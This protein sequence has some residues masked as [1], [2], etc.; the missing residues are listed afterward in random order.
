MKI[1]KNLQTI[2]IIVIVAA[3]L[4]APLYS[5]E[6]VTGLDF[7]DRVAENY[8]TIQDYIADFD[9]T[10]EENS[11]SGLIYYKN[12]NLIRIDFVDPEEQVLVTDGSVM[13]VYV[14]RYNVTLTQRLKAQ[15]NPGGFATGEGLSMLRRNYQIA[16]LDSP[17]PQPLDGP[18]G[19]STEPVYKL[20][21]TWRNTAQGFREITIS[22]TPD[23]FIRRMTAVTADRRDIEFTFKDIQINQN[24]PDERF[25]YDSPPSS[26]N[27]DN[28]LYGAE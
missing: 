6:I 19:N 24:I 10:I 3:S 15:T 9:M 26:N 11:M 23:L 17:D 14:P 16:F 18:D 27:Y 7:F 20:F 21:L 25:E 13:Q 5:Q 8:A 2:A 22:V 1:L 4:S 12:P 28:F